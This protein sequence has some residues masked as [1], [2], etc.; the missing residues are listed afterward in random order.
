VWFEAAGEVLIWGGPVGVGVCA[1]EKE[2]WRGKPA[3]TKAGSHAPRAGWGWGLKTRGGVRA[4][5]AACCAPTNWS[6][7]WR[8]W[9]LRMPD[10]AFV[11]SG[12]GGY[13]ECF[14]L[15]LEAQE[16]ERTGVL[17]LRDWGAI[18]AGG[19]RPHS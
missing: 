8:I 4:W 17:F 11:N 14:V 5:G 18:G 12:L 2:G 7:G 13:G 1:E 3:A 19:S 16:F 6:A 10:K 9:V 15:G